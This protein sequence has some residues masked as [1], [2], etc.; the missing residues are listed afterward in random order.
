MSAV[1]E[2]PSHL[3]EKYRLYAIWLEADYGSRPISDMIIVH[4]GRPVSFGTLC[5]QFILQHLE[6]TVET[7]GQKIRVGSIT[8]IQKIDNKNIPKYELTIDGILK[9]IK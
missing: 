3:A 9:E 6:L 1:N 7:T 8:G 5:E 2:P 4:V